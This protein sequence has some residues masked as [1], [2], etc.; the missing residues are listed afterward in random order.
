MDE[1]G[2]FGQ[3]RVL[4]IGLGLMGGS[5]ALALKEKVSWIGGMDISDTALKQARDL[6]IF[7]A[8]S[9]Q[10]PVLIP[11]SNVIILGAPVCQNIK[12]V[13]TLH[14]WTEAPHILMD[15]SSTKRQIVEAFSTLPSNFDPIGG[16]PMCGSEKSSI[17]YARPDLF[18]EATFILSPLART[19]QKA[20]KFALSLI[21]TISAQPL[22]LDPDIHDQITAQTSHFPYL[23]AAA[24]C[25]VTSMDSKPLVSSGFKST[26]RLA[27]TSLSMIRDILLTNPDN[28]LDSITRYKE[29]LN[30]IE[31]ILKEKDTTQ[32]NAILEEARRKY[33]SL[34]S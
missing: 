22:F 28:V 10:L 2:F 13:Q 16:H 15:L 6:K 1:P 23:A 14:Q 32:L 30:D 3:S 21:N 31:T 27:G 11:Q 4:F 33:L 17:L 8:L 34:I 29:I 7:D 19:S 9:D 18:N 25:L 12:L 20:K 5:L 26:S 24:L